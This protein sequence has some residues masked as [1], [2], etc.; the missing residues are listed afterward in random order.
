MNKTPKWRLPK[1]PPWKQRAVNE[2]SPS[3]QAP[4]VRPDRLA[5]MT[6]E[7]QERNAELLERARRSTSPEQQP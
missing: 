3:R 2:H 6:P 1:G 5:D 4:R 7:E